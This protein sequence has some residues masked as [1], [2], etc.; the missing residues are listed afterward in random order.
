VRRSTVR[1]LTAWTVN[2]EATEVAETIVCELV[3]NAV[4][5]TR[6]DDDFVAVRL[7]ATNGNIVIE[8]W[9][10]NDRTEP[11][12]T[13]PDADSETGRGLVLVDALSSRWSSY[14]ARSGGVVVWAQLPG[15]MLPAPRVS[16]DTAPMPRRRPQAVPETTASLTSPTAYSTD[17]E[18]LAR[19]ADRL[20]ALDAWH[21]PATDQFPS[22]VL[23]L[24]TSTSDGPGRDLQ[25]E[26]T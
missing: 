17:P 19:V 5:A 2:A 11:R 21:E 25:K 13:H 4:Q 26:R 20:R 23:R 8:V 9:N 18:I 14:Q 1:T 10:R 3:T 22:A 7:S 24:A 12:P 6:P 15:R 16:D